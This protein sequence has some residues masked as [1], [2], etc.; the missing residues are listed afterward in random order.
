MKS[1]LIVCDVKT[2]G[3]WERARMIKDHLSDEYDI[4]LVDQDEFKEYERNASN[5]M[6]MN[7]FNEFLR[8]GNRFKQYV[9]NEISN[10]FRFN[11]TWQTKNHAFIP[12]F[13]LYINNRIKHIIK[14]KLDNFKVVPGMSTWPDMPESYREEYNNLLNNEE[15]EF[16]EKFQKFEDWFKS[17][18]KE[19]KKYDLIYLMFHTILAWQEVQRLMFQGHKFI[20]VVTGAPVVKEVF[21]NN[22]NGKKGEPYF[23]KLAN[24]SYGILCNNLISL[25]ELRKIYKGPTGYIP[26]G[27]D[28]DIF[29]PTKPYWKYND[30]FTVGF[31]GKEDS[32]KGLN[33]IV[34]PAC[35]KYDLN[36]EANTRNYTNKLSQEEMVDFY[37]NIHV[38]VVASETDGTPNPALE[39]AACG[40]PIVTVPVGNMPEFI[41]DG[42]NGYLVKRNIDSIG[43]TLKF[44]KD[45]IEKSKEMGENARQ[46][47]LDGWTWEHSMEYERSAIRKVF[48]RME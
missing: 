24:A 9:L 13:K 3:G 46:T 47:V 15:K 32:G 25:K 48:R 10:Y 45:N 4:D 8:E 17:K 31:V 29:K 14:K 28:P 39:A 36:L 42:W 26:R 43:S 16:Q 6:H 33:S 18:R 23:K 30:E 1:I 2:W 41:K 34:I 22:N 38:L 12:W 21:Y 5:F 7:D 19:V 11:N 40:R 35:E 27:V 44:L 37:N 20:S